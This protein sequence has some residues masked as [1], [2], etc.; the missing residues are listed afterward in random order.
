MRIQ[1]AIQIY[2]LMPTFSQH[3]KSLL[4]SLDDRDSSYASTLEMASAAELKI[5]PLDNFVSAKHR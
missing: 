2:D 1:I 4:S 5:G 3:V